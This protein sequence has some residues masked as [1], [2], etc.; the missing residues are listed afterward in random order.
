M[1]TNNAK[2][3]DPTLLLQAGIDPKT[4][5]PTKL[6][7]GKDGWRKEAIKRALR[8]VDEQDAVNRYTWYNLPGNLSSQELERLL[9]YRGQLA[10]F[11]S[12]PLDEFFFLPYA[13]DG[14]LD[15]YGRFNTI[16]PIP[17]TEG[18]TDREKR[19]YAKQA[20]YFST[21]KL[22]VLY[23]VPL[24]EIDFTEHCVLLHD[25]TKQLSQTIISRQVIQDPLLDIMSDCIPFMRTN[26][27]NSTGIQGVRVGSQDESSN[28]KAAS[29]KINSAALEGEKYVPIVGFAE[30]Q[31][32]TAGQVAKSEEFML[33]MQS[34]DNF[35]LSLY[36]LD[37]GGLFEKKAH[38]LESEQAMNASTTG[39]VLQDGLSIRQRFCDIVN[40]VTGLGISC[41][42]SETASGIDQ[43]MDMLLTDEKDQS[44]DFQGDQPEEV[45]E[46]V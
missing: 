46:N 22:K 33:A 20:A 31:D 38:V 15:F 35:R 30:F 16:H 39:L 18:T 44:G 9:Y 37:S 24:E 11:Y 6:I 43:N 10:F 26:L 7:D 13:L 27:L 40:A 45:S 8:L 21:L 42:I 4:G 28:V 41:E 3:T 25:Y 2:L 29:L 36:G 1:A 32:L 19:E 12:E 17:I 5:L 14:G 34:L 23:D